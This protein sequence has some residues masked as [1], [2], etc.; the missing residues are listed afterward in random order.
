MKNTKVNST[1]RSPAISRHNAIIRRLHQRKKA[2][3]SI[4]EASPFSRF[5]R[6][7][8][9]VGAWLLLV[10][11]VGFVIHLISIIV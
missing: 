5:E 2:T 9:E 8:E 4:D 6:I 11:A 7:L 3:E 10:T 1:H